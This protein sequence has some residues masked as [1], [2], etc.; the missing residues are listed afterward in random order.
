MAISTPNQ[1]KDEILGNT[2]AADYIGVTP[3]TLEVWRCTKR[4]QI[5]FIKVGRLVKYRKSALDAFLES[6]TVGVEV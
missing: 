6:R 4:Y 5:P 2:D 3:R 1:P